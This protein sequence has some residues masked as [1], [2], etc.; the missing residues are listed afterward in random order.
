MPCPIS[1][2]KSGICVSMIA[3]IDS[4]PYNLAKSSESY[5]KE[6]A[7]DQS[8]ED[9][10]SYSTTTKVFW[11]WAEIIAMVYFAMTLALTCYIAYSC[12]EETMLA[13]DFSEKIEVPNPTVEGRILK[14][15]RIRKEEL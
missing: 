5:L 13:T 15:S 1:L 12:F 3:A 11:S 9:N 2:L 14:N 4:S 10:S 7:G 8:S 6:I